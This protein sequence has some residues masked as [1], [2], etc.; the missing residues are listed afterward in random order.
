M[1]GGRVLGVS[2]FYHDSAAA[3]VVDGEIVCAL[4]EERASR[5]KHDRAFPRR[6][7][8]AVLREADLRADSLDLVVYYELPYL[9]AERVLHSQLRF[10]PRGWRAFPRAVRALFGGKL[11]VENA[12]G[13]ALG[14]DGPVMLVPHHASHA[15]SAYLPSPF[16]EAAVL[17]VDG[18]GEWATTTVGR[19]RGGALE[20]LEEQRFPHSLG[21]F[22]AALTA[23]CGFRVNSG[24]YKLM[25]LAPYGAPRFADVMRRELIHVGDDG[26]VR[27]NLRHFDLA[28]DEEM[29]RPSLAGLLGGPPRREGA[30]M[31]EREADLAASA[32]R[33]TEEALVALARRAVA[34]AGSD[35]LCLAGGVAQN[36]VA[37]AK[38]LEAGVAREV[39]VQPAAGDAGGALGAALLGAQH[40][41][42][43]SRPTRPPGRDAMRGAL[44]GPTVTEGEMRAA[45]D[46]A[47]LRYERLDD[48]A[49]IA[50]AADALAGGA[51]IGWYQGR[52]EFGPRA[53]GAR[54]ILADPRPFAVRGRV[55]RGVKRR[56]DF[57]PF[58]PSVLRE[59]AGAWFDLDGD[60]A[61]MTRTARVRHF[62]GAQSSA[63]SPGDFAAWTV[64]APLAA[65]THVDG[66]ARVQTVSR[67]DHPRFHAL[68]TAFHQR[69]GVPVLLNTSFNLRGEPIVASP[70]DACRT[71]AHGQLDALFLGPF[72]VSRA[73]QSA[74]VLE[75]IDAPRCV[76]D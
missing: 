30:P 64:D 56:E 38:V 48:D 31:T 11:W 4:Q 23:F 33:V 72:A 63:A 44:L 40:R 29:V 47:G 37:V 8:E 7:V 62:R 27:L 65:V 26:T 69:V 21:L 34:Q 41:S 32:Q 75:R 46:R 1:S 55:N 25:G 15:A 43:G 51:V 42:R 57:R 22:Y 2:A 73:E 6:A 12:V 18:V 9:H 16:D 76:A 60:A 19:G 3:L 61:Y 66:S 58:A 10:A 74:A 54:S 14:Y 13:D 67:E 5:V 70:D 17:T 68:L 28:S 45:L 49:L 24:E 35:R 52:M 36:C 20:L 53:L 39:F 50:R 59:E 71:F